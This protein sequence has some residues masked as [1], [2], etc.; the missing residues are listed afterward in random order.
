MR[1]EKILILTPVKDAARYLEDYF[2]ALFALTYPP[3]NISIA[4]LEGDSADDTYRRLEDALPRL[5]ERYAS[6]GLWKKDF[7]F[8][9]PPGVPRYAHHLQVRRRTV[10]ARSR[11]QLLSRALRDEDW[12]LWLDVDVIEY[13]PDIIE[14]LLATGKEIVQPNCVYDYGGP[15]FDLNAWRDHGRLH[16]HDLRREGELVRLDAVGGTMLLVKADVHRD[17]LVFPP[18]P[19]GVANPLIRTNNYWLG[20]LETEGLGIMAHDMGVECWGMPRLEIRHRND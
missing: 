12:V 20:E 18:F 7:N 17:G 13:P 6:A 9:L 19:Y 11:N 4:F 3:Q 1:D 14:T 2:G 15:S 5:Q 10:L 8:R 16:L